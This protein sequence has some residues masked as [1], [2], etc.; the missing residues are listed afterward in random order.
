MNL[1][2]LTRT[3]KIGFLCEGPRQGLSE[4]RRDTEINGISVTDPP[5]GGSYGCGGVYRT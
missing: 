1:Y 4:I 2:V 3:M 5:R